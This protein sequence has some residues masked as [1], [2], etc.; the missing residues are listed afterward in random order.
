MSKRELSL[1]EK[2]ARWKQAT[3]HWDNNQYLQSGPRMIPL[4]RIGR[5]GREIALRRDAQVYSHVESHVERTPNASLEQ[6]KQYPPK[7]LEDRAVQIAIDQSLIEEQ[8][9]NDFVSNCV[10]RLNRK[11]NRTPYTR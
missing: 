11:Y 7:F 10:G 4:P 3:A 9:E 5:D 1:S 8:N 6:T 2:E